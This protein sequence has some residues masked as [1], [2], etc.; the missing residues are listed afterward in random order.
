[1][2]VASKN[3]GNGILHALKDF[4]YNGDGGER[5]AQRKFA[6]K[7]RTACEEKAVQG[8]GWERGVKSLQ[9]QLVSN[10]S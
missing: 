1:M 2:G 5:G 9:M 10:V 3:R 7:G 8:G 6:K 4:T